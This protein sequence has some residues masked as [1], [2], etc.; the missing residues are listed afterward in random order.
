MGTDFGECVGVRLSYRCIFSGQFVLP[1]NKKSLKFVEH[2]QNE[3]LTLKLFNSLPYQSVQTLALYKFETFFDYETSKTINHPL[4][5]KLIMTIDDKWSLFKMT[6]LYAWK[7]GS[8]N[9]GCCLKAFFWNWSLA[10]VWLF[11]EPKIKNSL[12]CKFAH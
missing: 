1:V 5:H 7:V 8:P 2:L 3:S 6:F 9:K 10:Q 11:L 4:D 12:S